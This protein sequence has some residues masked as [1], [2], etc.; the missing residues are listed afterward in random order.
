MEE[1]V[2]DSFGKGAVYGSPG[3]VARLGLEGVQGAPIVGA[4]SS[5]APWRLQR[6]AKLG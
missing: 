4:S 2:I 1:T 5:T 6:V 3:A